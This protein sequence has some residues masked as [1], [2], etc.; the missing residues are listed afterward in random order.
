[1]KR[2]VGANWRRLG[3]VRFGMELAHAYQIIRA[4]RACCVTAYPRQVFTFVK[5]LGYWPDPALPRRRNEKDLWRKIFDRNPTFTRLSDKLEAKNFV[6]NISP[7]LNVPETLWTGTRFEDIPADLFKQ[8]FM[9][10]ANHGAGWN[11]AIRGGRYNRED[12]VRRT[13]KWMRRQYG[14]KHLQWGYFDIPPKL[15]AEEL[16]AESTQPGIN[17]YKIY[18]GNETVVL[19]FVRQVQAGGMSIEG[20]LDEDGNCYVERYDSGILSGDIDVPP[21]LGEMCEMAKTF[22]RYFD[23]VRCDFYVVSG[24]IYFSEFSFHPAAGHAWI[25]HAGLNARFERAWDLRRSW[26]LTT[27]QAGW[28]GRYADALRTILD[29]EAAVPP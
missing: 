25:D 10:K 4:V 20:V 13:R 14:R 1:M 23:F 11:I 22:S 26:F 15:F 7:S 2:G 29:S 21:E 17:E 12:L 9:V 8:D 5:K 18:T 6:R 27:P 24:L 16:L 19:I 3:R 28:R